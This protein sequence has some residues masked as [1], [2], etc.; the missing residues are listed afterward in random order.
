M[1]AQLQFRFNQF[2]EQVTEVL[3]NLFSSKLLC[4]VTLVG[5]DDIPIEAHK[6]ILAAFSRVLKHFIKEEDGPNMDVRITG[7]THHDIDKIIQFIYLGEVSVSHAGVNKFLRTAKFLGLSQLSDQCTADLEELNRE[8]TIGKVVEA[9][10][11]GTLEERVDYDTGTELEDADPI[12]ENNGE[13]IEN[14][15]MDEYGI[16]INEDYE[17]VNL[18]EDENDGGKHNIKVNTIYNFDETEVKDLYSLVNENLK[19][20]LSDKSDLSTMPLCKY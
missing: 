12:A 19:K 20:A 17:E 13:E 11:E 1:R 7:M 3:L 4:D 16:R 10:D 15:D 18:H 8:F 5:D 2:P 9:N 6:V 14:E